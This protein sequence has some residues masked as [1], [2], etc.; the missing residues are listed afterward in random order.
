MSPDR[1]FKWEKTLPLFKLV[2]KPL[3]FQLNK[4]RLPPCGEDEKVLVTMRR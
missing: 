1:D 2:L 4:V 3:T